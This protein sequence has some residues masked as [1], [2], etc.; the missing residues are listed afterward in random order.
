MSD[1]VESSVRGFLRSSEE[2]KQ[3]LEAEAVISSD[4]DS[5]GSSSEAGPPGPY[6]KEELYQEQVEEQRRILIVAAH[7][8][9]Y[10]DE[11]G[12]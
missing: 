8:D 1:T 11:Q 7:V 3:I 5:E 4:T 10:G 9:P 2:L 12:W 6:A